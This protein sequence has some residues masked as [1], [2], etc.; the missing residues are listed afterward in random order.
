MK[1]SEGPKIYMVNC[2]EQHMHGIRN[3]KNLT[4]LSE[5]KVN[6]FSTT[7]IA[8]KFRRILENSTEQ[9]YLLLSGYVTLNVIA[10]C[11]MTLKHDRLNLLIFDARKR[12]YTKRTITTSELGV[13]FDD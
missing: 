2:Q 11:I 4:K 12:E 1:P 8:E 13:V 6:A 3:I 5:G 10:A 7:R 9:D